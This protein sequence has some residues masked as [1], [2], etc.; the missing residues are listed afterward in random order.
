MYV[1]LEEGNLAHRVRLEVDEIR[2]VGDGLV[3]RSW[4]QVVCNDSGCLPT[5]ERGSAHSP[6]PPETMNIR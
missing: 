1:A 2:L 5:T 3:N 4:V 6:K